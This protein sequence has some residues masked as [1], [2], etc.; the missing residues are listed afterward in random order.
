MAADDTKPRSI[1]NAGRHYYFVGIRVEATT[2]VTSCVERTPLPGLVL[3]QL[4]GTGA[5]GRVYKGY[6]RGQVV[7]VKVGGIDLHL[8]NPITQFVGHLLSRGHKFTCVSRSNFQ[9]TVGVP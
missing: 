3:G 8:F 4:L 1:S 2:P 7:A 5:F 6:H 9:S